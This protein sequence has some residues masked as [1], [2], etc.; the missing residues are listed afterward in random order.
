MIPIALVVLVRGS[1]RIGGMCCNAAA[2]KADI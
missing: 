2:H 1:C